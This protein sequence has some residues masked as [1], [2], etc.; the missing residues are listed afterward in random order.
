MHF[1]K[2]QSGSWVPV[3]GEYRKLSDL[4]K[5]IFVCV[6]DERHEI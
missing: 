4:I 2:L 6:E 1:L 5:K 3:N